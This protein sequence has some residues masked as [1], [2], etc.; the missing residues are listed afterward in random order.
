MG[1]HGGEIKFAGVHR[2]E[3]PRLKRARGRHGLACEA[4]GATYPTPRNALSVRSLVRHV[5][6]PEGPIDRGAAK[7]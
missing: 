1:V 3:I 4:P 6:Y 5:F 7:F 2:G